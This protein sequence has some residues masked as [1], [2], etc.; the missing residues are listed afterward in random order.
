MGRRVINP[1]D[2]TLLLELRNLGVAEA[3]VESCRQLDLRTHQSLQETASA[4]RGS[5]VPPR[6]FS[7][8]SFLNAT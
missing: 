5:E 7:I 1:S 8:E 4:C 6:S 2:F 3:E